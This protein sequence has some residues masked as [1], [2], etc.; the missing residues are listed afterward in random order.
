[1]IHTHP[2]SRNCRVNGE[3]VTTAVVEQGDRL[4]VGRFEMLF[5]EPDSK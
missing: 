3:P 2:S 1:M 4:Q 5:Q